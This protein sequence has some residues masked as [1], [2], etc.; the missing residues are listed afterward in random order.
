MSEFDN[1]ERPA[2]PKHG[3]AAAS[4]TRPPIGG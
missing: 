4:I 3:E 1:V 2:C